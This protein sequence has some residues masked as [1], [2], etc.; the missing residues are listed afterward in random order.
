MAIECP[1]CH[2][3]IDSANARFCPFCQHELGISRHRPGDPTSPEPPVAKPEQPVEP[4][5]D[6]WQRVEDL[7]AGAEPSPPTQPEE[8]PPPLPPNPRRRLSGRWIAL[9]AVGVVV[10]AAIAIAAGILGTRGSDTGIAD[11]DTVATVT[12]R[13]ADVTTMSTVSSAPEQPTDVEV[14]R[15]PTPTFLQTME[16]LQSLLQHYEMRM[17]ELRLEINETLPDV[18]HSL[19]DEMGTM[20]TDLSTA[21]QTYQ[22]ETPPPE[23][24]AARQN[25]LLAAWYMEEAID[26]RLKGAQRGRDIG[27]APIPQGDEAY[28]HFQEARDRLK[29]YTSA[30]EKYVDA[31]P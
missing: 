1:E 31:L 22:N 23:Y 14:D 29:D 9:I 28:R 18:P 13:V 10:L 17:E 6:S 7:Y 20:M 24:S 4:P 30:Y 15:G 3:R 12:T 27:Y 5:G 25:L 16:D 21:V 26:A 11:E 8:P 2:K 19:D